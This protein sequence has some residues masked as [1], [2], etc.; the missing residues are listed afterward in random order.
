MLIV[1]AD[2]FNRSAIKTVLCAAITTNMKLGQ[3]PGNVQVAPRTSGLPKPSVVNVSQIVT[4]DRTLM[5]ERIKL[6][7]PDT[8]RRI[9]DGVR[10]VLNV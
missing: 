9:D 10:L 2:S 3:A 4:V 6:L 5:T 8:M 1:Q 7:D